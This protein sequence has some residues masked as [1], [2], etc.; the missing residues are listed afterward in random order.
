MRVQCQKR[1]II[2]CGRSSRGAG[3]VSIY[4]LNFADSGVCS[5]GRS[6]PQTPALDGT[7]SFRLGL[8]SDRVNHPG[9]GIGRSEAEG[10]GMGHWAWGMGH[11][12]LG[13]PHRA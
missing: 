8:G 6:P 13:I 1:E 5:P 10:W 4:T 7:M 2:W 3:C 11:W 12:A 9:L